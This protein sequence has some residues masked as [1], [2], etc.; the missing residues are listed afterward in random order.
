M[1]LGI[2]S[3]HAQEGN[4]AAWNKLVIEA[5]TSQDLYAPLEAI[6]EFYFKNNKYSDFVDYLKSLAQKKKSAEPFV[7][8][9]RAL[10]RYQHLKYLEEKQLWDE[11]FSQGNAYRNELTEGCKMA[12]AAT[13]GQEPLHIYARL[14]LWQF[15]KDQHDSFEE[16]ALSD[17]VVS[18]IEYSARAKDFKPIKEVADKF[19]VYKEKGR[20]K[21]FYKI[22]AQKLITSQMP[23]T[24][25]AKAASKFYQE[26][27]LDLSENIYDAYI[28]RVSKTLPKEELIRVL[29][30]IASIFAYKDE[31]PSDPFYAEKIFKKLEDKAGKEAFDQEVMYLRG[32]NLEK[33]K[34]YPQAKAVFD[35]LALRFPKS[36]HLDEVIF[37]S[38]LISA[39]VLRDKDKAK[40]YFGKLAQR[41]KNFT[42]QAVSGLYQLGLLSQWE[43]DSNAARNFYNRLLDVA[44]G[45]F[46]DT[47]ALA[48]ERLK[49]IEESKPIEYNLKTFLDLSLKKENAG[50][51]MSKIDLR[52]QPYQVK[53][54]QRVS[55][56]STAHTAPTGCMHIELQYL[57]SGHLGK[58]QTPLASQA[59]FETSYS[60]SGTKEIN[61]V[62]VSPTGIIDRSLDIVDIH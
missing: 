9:Y 7:N 37:K 16:S 30:E 36:T 20:S 61:L 8:Y 35:S 26:G 10:A 53:R 3:V 33:A 46:S 57:W 22:Y 39:Y 6:K 48:R 29:T 4:L 42:A 23:D 17:L 1:V 27:N 41:E 2:S 55:V 38:G 32:F 5:K 18:A 45:N 54:K 40:E 51:D 15:H 11:Y 21:E 25:L 24:E 49:E 50:Y 43:E 31:G 14:L 13:T 19:F 12:I 44:A 34:E 28:D 59:E 62:V 47:V 58:A 56:D 60:S 52:S